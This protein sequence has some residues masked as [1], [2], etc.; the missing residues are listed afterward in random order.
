MLRLQF[1]GRRLSGFEDKVERQDKMGQVTRS[2]RK[3]VLRKTGAWKWRMRPRAEK[4]WT[5][6]MERS[7][8][9]PQETQNS[10]KENLQQQL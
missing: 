9:L 8:D 4:S 2:E 5:C 6:E 7:I 1:F 3:V 10:I